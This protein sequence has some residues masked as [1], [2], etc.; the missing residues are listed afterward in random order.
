MK[1]IRHG[2]DRVARLDCSCCMEDHTAT[3]DIVT[4]YNED[5]DK[6]CFEDYAL[7]IKIEDKNLMDVGF[8]F[9][10][11]E[12]IKFKRN[13]KNYIDGKLMTAHGILIHTDQYEELYQVLKDG[14]TKHNILSPEEVDFIEN[15]EHTFLDKKVPIELIKYNPKALIKKNT[16]TPEDEWTWIPF[17]GDDFVLSVDQFADEDK[18]TNKVWV[19]DTVFGFKLNEEETKK[20]VNKM[21]RRYLWNEWYGFIAGNFEGFMTKENV[22]KFLSFLYYFPKTLK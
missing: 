13:W 22:V 16:Y 20:D 6:S 18:S 12:Y 15:T 14:L 7:Y 1:I 11:K 4:T 21:A 10:L 5:K 3:F 17:M 2:Y 9:R 19:A 8:F